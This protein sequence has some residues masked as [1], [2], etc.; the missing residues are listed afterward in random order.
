MSRQSP[1]L[2][3]RFRAPIILAVIAGV[4]VI[5]ASR[6]ESQ[7]QRRL[8]SFVR[9][10]LA[11]V[12]ADRDL[13]ARFN[14]TQP[15]IARRAMMQIRSILESNPHA[16][17]VIAVDVVPGDPSSASTASPS[18]ASHTAILRIDTIELLRLGLV[19]HGADASPAIVSYS[20]P[21]D[22]PP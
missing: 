13:A 3:R 14:N 1:S 8:E 9:G 11:D 15:L 10:M 18:P 7:R 21:G 19:D 22:A 2:L 16:A 17:D 4:V 12:A 5:F 20:I 6:A